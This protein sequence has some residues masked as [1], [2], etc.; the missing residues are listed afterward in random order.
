LSPE[1]ALP[2]MIWR[3]RRLRALE[4]AKVKELPVHA[5][6]R[7]I[8][9]CLLVLAACAGGATPPDATSD[10][11]PPT[12]SPAPTPMDLYS[13]RVERLDG[14]ASDLAG[15]R[16]KVTL[17]VN[18]ASEC[19][20]TPQYAGLQRLHQ[21]LAGRGFAVLGFPSNDFGGQEPGTPE[22]I[23]TF[24]TTKYGVD[25]PLFAKV[26]TK[27]GAGQSPVYEL[28]GRATG[29]L[30]SWNFCKYLV[31]KDGKPV[32]FFGSRTAPDAAELRAAIEQA[33]Q[34]G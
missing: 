8:V 27:A 5:T 31:G 2:A 3:I 32:A 10:Q 33:L 15:Y 4:A 17:I 19:G 28:L 30:P 14:T 34:A 21:E 13:L 9:T 23:Q 25:F 12:T 24:C 6:P 22:Q 11:P 1:A 26:R 29:S 7:S 18:V 16:G 20:F